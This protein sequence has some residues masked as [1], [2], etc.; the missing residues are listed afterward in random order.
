M[1]Q[2]HKQAIKPLTVDLHKV[3]S[4]QIEQ[5]G[6]SAEHKTLVVHFKRGSGAVYEY[7]GVTPEQFAAFKGADSIGSFFG[8]HFKTREFR[9]FV[10]GKLVG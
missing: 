5:I 8:K 6:Y 9:K 2:N 3:E 7:P 10:G 4:S 1:S